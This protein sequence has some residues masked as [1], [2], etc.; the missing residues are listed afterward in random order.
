MIMVDYTLAKSYHQISL[1]SFLLKRI[2]RLV[3]VTIWREHIIPLHYNLHACTIGR[4]T[5]SGLHLVTLHIEKSLR[6]DFLQQYQYRS[7][8][9]WY[10][11]NNNCVYMLIT[12]VINFN[13]HKDIVAELKKY[14]IQLSYETLQTKDPPTYYEPRGWSHMP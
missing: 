9:G 1:S 4:D 14:C 2:G 5:D 7:S 10:S 13:K 6:Q 8:W 11:T 12:R 3:D